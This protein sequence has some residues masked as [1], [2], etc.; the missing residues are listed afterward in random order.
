MFF[1]VLSLG[2]VTAV[3]GGLIKK[4]NCPG[5]F[6]D[7]GNQIAANDNRCCVFIAAR[8]NLLD[9][10]DKTCGEDAHDALRLSFHDAA[11]FSI[12]G[13]P[14]LGGGADG[15][16]MAFP[17]VEFLNP[18]NDGLQGSTSAL[19]DIAN[20]HGISFGDIIQFA[21]AVAVAQC[22]GAPRLQFLAGRPNATIPAVDGLVPNPNQ[23]IPI[24]KARMLDLGFTPEQTVSLLTSHTMAAQDKQNPD[25]HGSPFDSTPG[26]FDGQFFLDTLL[27]SPVSGILPSGVFRLNSDAGFARDS[28]TACFWQKA[29]ADSGFMTN[30][31]HDQMARMAVIGQNTDN[32]FDCTEAVP[33]PP[34][35]RRSTRF[36][37]G[38]SLADIDQSCATSPFPNVGTDPGPATTVPP[39]PPQDNGTGGS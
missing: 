31:F 6:D 25:V 4:S 18:D 23:E 28:E 22:P 33:N 24:I 17:D 2:L 26:D 12:S 3:S 10:F 11:G 20:E 36:P 32:L 15:S 7:Q 35:A 9:R 21:A 37:A 38:S 8:D 30:N 34:G 1:A 29:V 16:I 39:V 13:G 14:S 5:L 27:H 19:A